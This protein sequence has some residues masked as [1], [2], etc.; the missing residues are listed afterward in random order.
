M[1]KRICNLTSRSGWMDRSFTSTVMPAYCS[2]QRQTLVVQLLEAHTDATLQ[3]N[4]ALLQ[5]A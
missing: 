3:N 5:V 2:L 1:G 4:A